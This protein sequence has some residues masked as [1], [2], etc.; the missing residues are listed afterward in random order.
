MMLVA[1]CHASIWHRYGDIAPQRYWGHD[2]D[3][4]GLRDV[5]GHVTIRLPEVDFLWVVHMHGDHAS[6]WRRYG[7]IMTSSVT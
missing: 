1:I 7:D 6:I 2:L 4:L 3:L 5:I